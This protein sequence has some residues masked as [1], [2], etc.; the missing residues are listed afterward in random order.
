MLANFAPLIGRK[1]GYIIYFIEC[2]FTVMTVLHSIRGS[3]FFITGDNHDFYLPIPF[4]FAIPDRLTLIRQQRA[5]AAKKRDEE[6]AG[7]YTSLLLLIRCLSILR[8]VLS[9][10]LKPVKAKKTKTCICTEFWSV[11]LCLVL[12]AKEERKAEARRWP[13]QAKWTDQICVLGDTTLTSWYHLNFVF[14]AFIITYR[15][16]NIYRALWVRDYAAT[17]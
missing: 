1:W 6:K 12:A 7:T 10:S 3:F 5:E 14:T 16:S 17:M 11:L 4:F 15:R 13:A 2:F 8:H 9:E